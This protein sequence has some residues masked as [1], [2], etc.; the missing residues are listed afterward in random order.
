MAAGDDEPL[1]GIDDHARTRGVDV[2]LTGRK[3]EYQLIAKRLIVH[4]RELL[5][6]HSSPDRDA[7]NARRYRLKQGGKTRNSL[8]LPNGERDL[9]VDGG[10]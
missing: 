7:H 8:T 5:I 2:P 10:R 6:S 1:L 3:R 9:R 4:Q